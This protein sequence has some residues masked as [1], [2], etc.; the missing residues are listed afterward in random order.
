MIVRLDI[1]KVM[2]RL[3][4]RSRSLISVCT[5]FSMDTEVKA[6]Y[7]VLD[8][9]PEEEGE[10]RYGNAADFREAVRL[11]H[12]SRREEAI[13]ILSDLSKDGRNDSISDMYLAYIGQLPE[14]ETGNVFRFVRK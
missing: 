2:Y 6:V 12:L 4:S 10:K 11:F 3:S 14:D 7:E 13:R 9:L 8:C 5:S 1:S